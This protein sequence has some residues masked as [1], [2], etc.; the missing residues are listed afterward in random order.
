MTPRTIMHVIT[1]LDHGGSAQNTMLTALGHDRARYAPIMVAGTADHHD[2]QGGRTATKGNVRR[3]QEAGIAC[4]LWPTLTRS[5]SPVNDVQALVQLVRLFRREHPTLIHT[6]T[7]KAGALGRTAAALA[8]VKTLVH[9]PH[10]HVYYGH[11]NRPIS[12]GFVQIERALARRTTRLIALTE[13]E[14]DEHLAWGVGTAEQ[15]AVI[16]SGIDLARFQS[17]VGVRRTALPGMSLKP[18]AVVIGSIG[19]LTDVKGHRYLIEAVAQMKAEVPTLHLLLVGGG[20]RRR[21]LEQLAAQRGIADS[22]TFAGERQD[23]PD[24]L[25][26]LDVFV[27]PSLN[28]GMGRALIEAMAAGRPVVASRVGGVP[29]LIKERCNG[30]L[31]PPADAGALARALTE[32]LQRPQWA[33]DLASAASVTIGARFGAGAMVEAIESVYEDALKETGA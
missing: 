32:L 15:F 30:L 1:R 5:V 11:F 4:R 10:G 9:T 8:G 2:A 3:L 19:W 7:S 21:E 24:C 18:D 25:A 14:R 26:V 16:P 6:H 29:A 23:I 31:V 17:L 28:E 20:N 22:V 33:K 27:L 13:A 12:R